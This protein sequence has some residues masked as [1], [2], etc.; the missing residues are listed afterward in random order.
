MARLG[1]LIRVSLG[2]LF[3][4]GTCLP[5]LVLATLLLP[6]RVLRIKLC[7]GYGKL[8][9]S[10]LIR[11]LV[12]C[13]LAMSHR[14]RIDELKPAIYVSNHTSTLDIFLGMWL[15]PYGGCGI[16]KKEIG[17]IPLFGWLYRL[18]GHLLIDRGDREKAIAALE[19]TAR[20]VREHE[21][22][23]WL[24]PE[25]TRSRD[26]RLIPF[27]KGFVH[28]AIATGL[29]VIPV[30]VHG[31]HKVWEARTLTLSREPLRVDVL[32]PVDTSG[33]SEHSVEQH[34][35]EVRALFLANLP[36]DQHPLEMVGE[37]SGSEA[38]DSQAA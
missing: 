22:S 15:C 24:W 34:V 16:A 28:L 7:N 26:G 2:L 21:L 25:G 19:E 9:G 31:A 29:P 18:S 1:L 38:E 12:R 23:I 5:F 20:L 17:N 3:V 35:A 37:V 14:E 33:W 32:E 11:L 27:K 36:A 6:W 13:P 4:F 10:G 8:V 30:V